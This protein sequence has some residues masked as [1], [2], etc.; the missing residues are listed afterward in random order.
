MTVWPT[1]PIEHLTDFQTSN[2]HAN[3]VPSRPPT[4]P[5]PPQQIVFAGVFLVSDAS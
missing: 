5:C 2:V 1:E 4:A 3:Q